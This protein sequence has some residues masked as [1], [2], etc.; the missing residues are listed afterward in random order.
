MRTTPPLHRYRVTQIAAE[1]GTSER[2]M[3]M[4]FK[5]RNI[6]PDPRGYTLAQIVRAMTDEAGN[7]KERSL[8]AHAELQ[9]H[10]A[11]LAGLKLAQESGMTLPRQEALDFM[12]GLMRRLYNCLDYVEGWPAARVK[13]EGVLHQAAVGFYGEHG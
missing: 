8:R 6:E 11:A 4:R 5:S 10:Q 3:R 7:A 1:L 12:K 2:T 13:V 9:E